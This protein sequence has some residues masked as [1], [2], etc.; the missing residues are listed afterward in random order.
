MKLSIKYF[1]LL[2]E[3]TQCTEEQLVFTGT[4]I[5]ELR[6]E[7]YAKYPLLNGKDFQIAQ[8]QVLVNNDAK[9]TEKEVALLPPF[10]GG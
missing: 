6:K 4:D 10:A 2:A 8:D 1:G 3:I 9:I 7:L 5:S